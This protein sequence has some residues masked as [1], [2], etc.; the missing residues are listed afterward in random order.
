M[1]DGPATIPWRKDGRVES[2]S[3]RVMDSVVSLVAPHHF[4]SSV[5]LNEPAA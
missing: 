1:N 4:G 5:V 2:A 3:E